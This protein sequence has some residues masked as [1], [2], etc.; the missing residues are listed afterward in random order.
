MRKDPVLQE[1][2][3]T[4]YEYAATGTTHMTDKVT[5]VPYAA[6]T[7]PELWQKEVD[8]IF[9]KVPLCLATTAELKGKNS[10]KAMD[11]VGLPVL[12]TRDKN[13]LARA[14]L[15]VCS[16]RGAPVAQKGCG[17]KKRFA[18]AYHGWTY[19]NDGQLIGVA[20]QDTFGE[21]DKSKLGLRELP[22][23]EKAG[24]IFVCLTP[25]ADMDLENYM[26]GM[27]DDLDAAN[28]KDWAYL[29]TREIEGANWKIAF[30]GYLEGYHFA[31]LH[32]ET[33]HPRTISNLM[34]YE[35]FGP[36][37]RIG[38]A[39]T[40]IKDKLDAAPKEEWGS[41]ENNGFDF[42]RI[43][44]P[45]I[46]IFLAPEITQIAQLFPGDAPDKNKT[47]LTFYRKEGPKDEEDKAGLE[48]MMDFLKTVVLE[49]DYWIGDLI[50]KGLNSNAHQNIT[51]GKNERGNQYFHEW[52][53]WYLAGDDSAPKPVL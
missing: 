41:M 43:L 2:A 39:Q 27:L 45:N 20:E 35:A 53:G 40:D 11:A 14:F 3:E 18:C 34:H 29:G 12:I 30:D 26:A 38:F 37:M 42:V 49:E 44:F 32:P 46:S 23:E 47:I 17:I 33:I 13:G 16:H 51:M 36:H 1:V 6:Y 50:Q 19:N 9:K 15:N 21:V 52:V 22:C 28:F 7:D 10:Y 5:Q 4:L 48:G 8:E 24:L 25:G 31:Q